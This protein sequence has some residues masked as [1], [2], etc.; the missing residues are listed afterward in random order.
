MTWGIHEVV[1]S[2][3]TFAGGGGGT[4]KS[5][6]LGVTHHAV[7]MGD[8]CSV[9]LFATMTTMGGDV[10]STFESST[11]NI[12]NSG[13]SGQLSIGISMSHLLGNNPLVDCIT[14]SA[15]RGGTHLIVSGIIYNAV[16]LRDDLTITTFATMGQCVSCPR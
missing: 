4:S 10:I 3:H 8:D 16:Q 12:D 6:T 9:A 11:N 14:S 13:L 2:I 5:E 7:R 15:D 1:D